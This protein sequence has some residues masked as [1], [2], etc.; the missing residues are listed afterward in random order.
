[1]LAPF[2]IR[3]PLTA[4][5]VLSLLLSSAPAWA[6]QRSGDGLGEY[7]IVPFAIAANGYETVL[8]ISDTPDTPA[9]VLKLRVLDRD[10]QPRLTANLYLKGAGTW[11]GGL[12][13][14]GETARLLTSSDS[15]LLVE[16]DDAVEPSS[17]VDFDFTAG[18]VEIVEMGVVDAQALRNAVSDDDCQAIADLWNDDA[19]APEAAL[20]PPEGGLRATARVVNVGKGTF[21]GVPATALKHFSNIVQHTAPSTAQPDLASTHDAGTATG[22]TRSVVC[23]DDGCVEDFW[24]NP[25]D[26]ASAALITH[27]ARDT[28]DISESLNARSEWIVT[29][30]TQAHYADSQR[31]SSAVV[32]VSVFD[33]AGSEVPGA[34]NWRVPEQ[35]PDFESATTTIIHQRS[36]MS[37]ELGAVAREP[38]ETRASI[39]FGLAHQ[40]ARN[41]IYIARSQL[42]DTGQVRLGFES[43]TDS[44]D[45]AYQFV[46]W[47]NSGR[48]YSGRPALVVP[49]VEHTHGVLPGND[50][51]P[52]R[53]NYGSSGSPV[54]SVRI[55]PPA[56]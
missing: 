6:I 32:A 53:A 18:S 1:M 45:A 24:E 2:P 7:L 17:Q 14:Q 12:T 30:P 13:R 3:I 10:G 36:V 25:I 23:D 33:R 52:Q 49:F 20:T 41:D 29:Y 5:V 50:G 55:N 56:E 38:G 47:A 4:A 42:P 48:R 26:A 34:F 11:A 43:Y 19:W 22:E 40:V 27:T 8:E 46:I 39:L 35:L 21:Y 54:T 9:Q 16:R 28:Y 15:C 37:I 31:F 51:Q 44:L